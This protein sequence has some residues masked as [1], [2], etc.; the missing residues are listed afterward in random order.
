MTYGKLGKT[1]HNLKLNISHK[2]MCILVVN[3]TRKRSVENQRETVQKLIFA[4]ALTLKLPGACV[5]FTS[6]RLPSNSTAIMA[7]VQSVQR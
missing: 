3:C 6:E 5:D 1:V 7:T 2:E 4:T